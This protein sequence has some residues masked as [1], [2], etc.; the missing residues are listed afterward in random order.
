MISEEEEERE[1]GEMSM[2]TTRGAREMSQSGY[3]SADGAAEASEAEA[4]LEPT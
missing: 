1:S 3:G 2:G 4:A